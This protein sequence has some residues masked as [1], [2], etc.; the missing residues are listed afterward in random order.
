[1]AYKTISITDPVDL[2]LDAIGFWAYHITRNKPSRIKLSKK[3][4]GVIWRK[5]KAFWEEQ[6]R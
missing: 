3:N 1:M 4:K 6:N 2:T 5:K